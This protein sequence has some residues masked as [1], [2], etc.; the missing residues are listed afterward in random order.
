MSSGT[1]PPD[2]SEDLSRLLG[3]EPL[4]AEVTD[5]HPIAVPTGQ[6]QEILSVALD[7]FVRAYKRLESLGMAY[8][9]ALD[10]VAAARK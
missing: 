6:A 10:T 1:L 8:A 7:E 5:E 9:R 2:S 3:P 4:I